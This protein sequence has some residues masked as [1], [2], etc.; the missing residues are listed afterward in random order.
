MANLLKYTVLSIL[1]ATGS[2]FTQNYS[3][4]SRFGLGSIENSQS[5]R[6][7][8]LGG[9]GTSDLVQDYVSTSNPASWS[10]L[11]STRFQFGT[12][13]IGN[14]S[15]D[16]SLSTYAAQ[17]YFSGFSFGFPVS[18]KHGIGVSL[19][20][21]PFSSVN[22]DMKLTGS[23]SRIG[24]DY[25]QEAKGE[26]GLAKLYIGS[27]WKPFSD[28]RIGAALN[29][30]FGK[31]SYHNTVTFNDGTSLKTDFN[32]SYRMKGVG[33]DAGLITPELSGFLGVED[34]IPGIRLGVAMNYFNEFTS[35]SLFA[36]GNNIVIDT[37]NYGAGSAKVPLKLSLGAS[38]Q[39]NR[40]MKVHFDVM[41]QSWSSYEVNG[42]KDPY[43]QD[44]TRFGAGF[45]YREKDRDRN[46][47]SYIYR[48]SVF[49]EKTPIVING[50][51]I[52]EIGA[53]V[54][55]SFSLSPESYF[56]L[57]LQYIHK[58]TT[59]SGLVKENIFRLHAGMSLGE[60]WFLQQER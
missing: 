16:A 9:F 57:G 50:Q 41:T 48:G 30:Y 22:Y 60:I 12:V 51:S 31:I 5:I 11:T 45:E 52:T 15:E 39:L 23:D 46:F 18:G 28:F 47:D 24:S 40:F 55:I 1:L 20:L 38:L 59:E 14:S 8:G 19:G 21:L 6:S 29:Y 4:Y 26:G 33:F 37:L 43:M 58:G 42:L 53:S 44:M 35:D 13:L 10:S 25:L 54:G 34:I 56:D 7:A 27:S 36:G 17:A 3:L 49:Y 2:S 32:K